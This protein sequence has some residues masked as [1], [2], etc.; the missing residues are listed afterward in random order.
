MAFHTSQDNW[1]AEIVQTSWTRRSS[2]R[3][4][5]VQNETPQYLDP[6]KIEGCLRVSVT[7]CK[8]IT[9]SK[10][11]IKLV[12]ALKNPN[13]TAWQEVLLPVKFLTLTMWDKIM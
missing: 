3:T 12:T 4:I 13:F 1:V 11:Q 2:W 5:L 8:M 10:Q 6:K 7:T 9:N